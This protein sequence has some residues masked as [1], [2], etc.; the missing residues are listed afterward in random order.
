MSRTG[1]SRLEPRAAGA[2][3]G[4]VLLLGGWL[5]PADDAP[6]FAAAD[7]AAVSAA[8]P[9]PPVPPTR[10]QLLVL[11]SGRVVQGE[12]SPTAGGY[13][14]E[15]PQGRMLVPFT[16]VR[17]QARDLR[18]AYRKL[19]D[20]M[21]ERTA[22]AHVE[23]AGWCLA[24]QLPDDARAELLAALELE[25]DRGSIRTMLR[26]LERGGDDP[27][28]EPAAAPAAESVKHPDAQSL[29][30]LSRESAQQF[31]LRI[32]PLLV[33][34]CGRAGCHD[35]SAGNDFRLTQV[36]VGSGGQR[37]FT[38]RNLAATLKFLNLD[39]P[40][41]SPLLTAPQGNHG[42]AGAAI[43]SGSR[44]VDQWAA[45]QHW[46]R[47][48][49]AERTQ[50]SPQPAHATS[51]QAASGTTA[52]PHGS[53]EAAAFPNRLAVPPAVPP[54]AD[55]LQEFTPQVVPR[56]SVPPAAAARAST[57][58]SPAAAGQPPAP[59]PAGDDEELLRLLREE[60]SD[61]FDP[62]IFNRLVHK[63]AS[64][65]SRLKRRAN[66]GVPPPL[67]N[68]PRQPLPLRSP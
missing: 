17:L 67:P 8:L 10:Q 11:T 65:D 68:A 39:S 13:L 51:A 14:V 43:F 55:T 9:P 46:V 41:R 26:R 12:I 15:F 63:A 4:V 38:E 37:L 50:P 23:L 56:E 3:L 40:D 20:S 19:R 27:P 45:L 47:Q 7:D 57:A 34:K 54:A 32:Q 33:N 48:V 44:G 60:A 18:D 52:F 31:V 49:A 59:F 22:N 61:P 1:T 53:G 24:H 5:A 2:L 58:P 28:G 66:P 29:A 16:Q 35:A 6:V 62:Q 36:R 25:P 30:G 21:P 42:P 64:D